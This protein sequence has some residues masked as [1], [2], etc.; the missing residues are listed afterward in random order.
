MAEN[1]AKTISRIPDSESAEIDLTT[2]HGQTFR[3]NCIY[4]ESDPPEF[5]L[6]FPPKKLPEDIDKDALCPISIKIEQKAL[7]LSAKIT[8]INGDRTLEMTAKDTVKPESLREYFRVD[9]KIP[10]VANYNP[11]GIEGDSHSWT[12]EGQTLDMSGSGILTILPEEPPVKHKIELKLCI[13]EGKNVVC[14]VGHIVRTKRLRRGRYQVA[15]HFDTMK[16]KERDTIISYCLQ[17]QRNRLR[18]KVHT[19]D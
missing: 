17:E 4:K 15:F 14:C 1:I 12:L 6:V 16:P 13:N 11:E 2:I 8:S 10:I 19:A 18:D 7:T 9:T 3:L 5:F